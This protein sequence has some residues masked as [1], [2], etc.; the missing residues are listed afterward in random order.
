LVLADGVKKLALVSADLIGIDQGI[1]ARVREKVS[2][3]M[4]T[5]FCSILLSATHTHSGPAVLED[6]F[7]GQT[8]SGYVEGL[9]NNLAGAVYLANKDLEPVRLFVGDGDCSLVGKNRRKKD[10]PTD[11]QVLVVRLEA[12]KGTKAILVNYACHPVVLG[13]DNLLVTSDYPFY[14]RASLNN[15]YPGAQV[16]FFNGATGDVN[17]GHNTQDSIKGGKH[18]HRTF[19]EAA[20]LGEM[21][22]REA[23]QAS[24]TAQW[25]DSTDILY[26][27]Q[28]MCLSLE[29]VPTADSYLE[30]AEAFR[31]IGAKLRNSGASFGEVNQAEV[32]TS[33]AE[34]MGRLQLAGEIE[35][36]REV[37]I[38]VFSLGD[39][40][41]VTLPG[42]FFHEFALEIKRARAPRRVFV[43][44]YTNDAVGYVVPERVYDEGGYEVNDSFRYYGL[45]SRL[46]RGTGEQ[47]T[48]TLIEMLENIGYA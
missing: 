27:H 38:A 17:V 35:A 29:E 43:L 19:T 7:L 32:W 18:G 46:V 9:V 8:D 44:G 34:Q 4:D 30:E 22:A 47:V 40:E 37:E 26:K 33:W 21:L 2:L 45:P 23:L 48:R 20:R 1:L 39:L 12:D 36:G 15:S 25:K 6:A 3:L 13:P 10:G 5:D 14:L 41:F 16:M 11:S 42:E 31:A 28:R 24:E